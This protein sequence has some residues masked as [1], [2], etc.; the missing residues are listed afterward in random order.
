M[1]GSPAE[2]GDIPGRL[3][4]G[5]N[6][7][8]VESNRMKLSVFAHDLASNPIGRLH[9]ILQALERL[10]HEIEVFGFL[11]SGG[12][13]YLPYRDNYI[14]TTMPSTGGILDVL[15]KSGRLAAAVSGG[16]VYAGKP[17]A[18]TLWPAL[19]ASGFGRRRPLW[20][21][22]ED[23]D[24][25]GLGEGG[26]WQRIW[27]HYI[28][29]NRWATAA[30]YGV[31][32]HPLTRCCSQVT[33]SSR[34]LQ[35]RYGGEI[36]R[37]G[38]DETFFDPGRPE[39][40]R[41]QAR[42]V[43]ELPHEPK[44]VLFAGTPH[45]HK[46]FGAIV[47]AVVATRDLHLLLCGDGGHPEFLRAQSLLP[48]RCHQVGFLPNE[49]MPVLLT[50][51]DIVPILQRDTEYARAQL[52]AKLLEALAMAR[53]IVVSRVGDLPAIIGDGDASPRGWCVSP[54]EPGEVRKAFAEILHSPPEAVERRCKAAR[55]YF[56][57]E[58]SVSA[59]A[60]KL[61]TLLER[62]GAAVPRA[63]GRR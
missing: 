26:W 47:D 12:E 27:R 53:P 13:V 46:G 40:A 48:G 58:C 50:A 21:D 31:I 29:I 30:K 59:N 16:V 4:I 43:L 54:G 19:L 57:D 15:G 28:R 63:D 36:I 17:L 35:R 52:P 61:A 2:R 62:S 5:V 44:M 6:L 51:A 23:D 39:F 37:H 8:A 55:Q 32:L 34:K 25:W 1:S 22:V 7:R 33:V 56:L 18:T 38:P 41:H 49:M 45:S 11:I 3:I 14:Y 24:V 20:L 60:A 10:G 9:P 42:H